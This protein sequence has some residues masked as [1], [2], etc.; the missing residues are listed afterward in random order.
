MVANVPRPPASG[1][2]WKKNHLSLGCII[3]GGQKGG[4]GH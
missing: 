1:Y 4:Q 3:T 2:L